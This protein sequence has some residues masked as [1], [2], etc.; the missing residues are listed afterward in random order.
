[1]NVYLAYMNRK[2]KVKIAANTVIEY[3]QQ[4]NVA[5]QLLVKPQSED[6]N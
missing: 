3:K 1:M 4:G 5:F 6:L 2:V